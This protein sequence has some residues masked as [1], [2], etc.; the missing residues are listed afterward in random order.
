MLVKIEAYHD[1]ELWCARGIGEDIFTQGE[2]FDQLIENIKEAVALHFE[3]AESLPDVL[4]LSEVKLS[5]VASA[6]S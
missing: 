6:T 3:G 5:S 2:T 4:L 1:G